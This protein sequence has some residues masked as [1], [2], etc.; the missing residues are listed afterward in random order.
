MAT[1]KAIKIFPYRIDNPLSHSILYYKEHFKKSH[2]SRNQI[3]F[4]SRYWLVLLVDDIIDNE[5]LACRLFKLRKYIPTAINTRTGA[6]RSLEIFPD[7]EVIETSHFIWDFDDGV[8][9]SEY[10]H[11]GARHLSTPL[12]YYL[13]KIFELTGEGAPENAVPFSTAPL[14]NPNT[15]RLLEQD[16][17]VKSF[18]VL[19]QDTDIPT[20]ERENHV[21]IIGLLRA[22]SSDRHG[23]I[24]ITIKPL[25]RKRLDKAAVLR[26][27]DR[28]I[29]G[30]KINGLHI[31]G[32]SA[33]Y[34]LLNNNL[35]SSYVNVNYDEERKVVDSDE[36]YTAVKTYYQ[37]NKRS[38]IS[39]FRRQ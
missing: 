6:E 28:L 35:M 34:D 7:E 1:T 30:D 37:D 15:R 23:Y 11:D 5:Y 21:D 4:G 27:A 12:N 20:F 24:E 31:E 8:I 9:I 2:I 38:I 25:H 36:F 22:L 13:N 10:N 26:A 14:R 33:K 39:S 17:G 18:T 3:E 16:E 29:E 32:E 19:V